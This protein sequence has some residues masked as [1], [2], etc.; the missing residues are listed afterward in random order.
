MGTQTAWIRVFGRCLVLGRT[1]QVIRVA[2]RMQRLCNTDCGQ[3]DSAFGNRTGTAS[4]SESKVETSGNAAG[5]F[6]CYQGKTDIGA[7]CSSRRLALLE[8]PD[9]G[10]E[11]PIVFVLR[12]GVDDDRL[13]ALGD[14]VRHPGETVDAFKARVSAQH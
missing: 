9:A 4:S 8:R 2:G 10:D 14:F 11:L 13:T 12:A 5:L 3:C 7:E 6:V 1:E